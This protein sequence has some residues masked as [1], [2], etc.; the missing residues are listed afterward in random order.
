[1]TYKT[2]KY[3]LLSALFATDKK[4]YINLYPVDG[5]GHV[6]YMSHISSIEREDG[7]GYKFNVSGYENGVKKTVFVHTTD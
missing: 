1:M 5:R 6:V 7:S 2:S 4:C 3:L